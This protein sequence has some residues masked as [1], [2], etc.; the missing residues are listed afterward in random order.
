LHPKKSH[1]SFAAPN[2]NLT[3]STPMKKLNF[4]AICFFSVLS[5]SSCTKDIERNGAGTDSENQSNVT[6]SY[7]EW[8]PSSM[9]SWTDT[10]LG[11]DPAIHAT[12]K[13]PVTESMINN[14]SIL[15]YA[16]KTDSD[17]VSAFPAAIYDSNNDYDLLYATHDFNGIQIFHT[18]NTGGI[19]ERPENNALRFRYILIEQ[20][21]AD[22]G[23]PDAPQYSMHELQTMTYDE[24]LNALG[25]P[26]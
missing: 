8:I 26:E 7:S 16:K 5:F 22:N 10:T 24:V 20:Q 13:A 14:N 9:L 15:V 21:V 4:L 18:R 25:I 2:S 23:R 1:D 19:Y 17:E 12:F 6:V 3:K 11:G